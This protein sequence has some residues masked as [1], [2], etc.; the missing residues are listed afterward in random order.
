M[1]LKRTLFGV[2][3]VMHQIFIRFKWQKYIIFHI[4]YIIAAPL[5]PTS[6]FTKLIDLRSEVCCDWPAIQCVLIGVRYKC[7]APLAYG[8]DVSRRDET[9]TIKPIINEAFVAVSED[10]IT[11]Y[12][13]LY[14]FLHIA[15]RRVNITI[16]A[17]V[18]GEHTTSATLHSSK[19]TFES[20]AANYLNMKH[21]YRLWVRSVQSWN[22][23]TL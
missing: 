18:I 3:G 22:R 13:D 23:S 8:D 5:C 7:Y 20:S 6:I 4:K 21:T 12:N 16:S 9:K 15:L 19:L 2:F 14:V 10:I 11:D 17:F 1:L